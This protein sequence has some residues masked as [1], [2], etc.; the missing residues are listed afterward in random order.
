MSVPLNGNAA[1]RPS[2][3]SATGSEPGDE[4]GQDPWVQ[5][6][7]RDHSGDLVQ[8]LEGRMASRDAALDLVQATFEKLLRMAP[9]RFGRI[10]RPRAYVRRISANL[11]NDWSRSQRAEERA[12]KNFPTLADDRVDQI[13]VLEA[14]DTLRRLEAALRQ[15]KP[16]T[17]EIF[18]AH[19]LHGMSYAEIALQTGLS[20]KGVE[21]QMSKAIA[22]ID[23]LLERS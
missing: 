8:S 11:A 6:L 13:A 10:E 9:A 1:R 21:K 23:R 18:L 2:P 7:Y 19:R 17:R 20:V 4:S 16:K 15:L 12:R 5:R 14:R 3:G 22:K